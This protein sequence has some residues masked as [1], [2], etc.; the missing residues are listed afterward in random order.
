MRDDL[1]TICLLIGAAAG[2]AWDMFISIF[3]G[4]RKN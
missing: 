2:L 4:L 3:C 1:P